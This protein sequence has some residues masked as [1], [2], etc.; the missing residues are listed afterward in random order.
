M[1]S[2]R[3][4]VELNALISTAKSRSRN[5]E[6]IKKE[7]LRFQLQQ[8]KENK[9]KIGGLLKSIEAQAAIT[10]NWSKLNE[11]IGSADGKKFRQNCSGIYA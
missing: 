10:E 5:K 6:I 1:I 7:K 9:D 8:D 11:I 4:P 2:E 3:T